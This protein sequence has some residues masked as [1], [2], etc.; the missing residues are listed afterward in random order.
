MIIVCEELYDQV[1]SLMIIRFAENLHQI[2]TIIFS[3]AE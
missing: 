3:L 1:C 2:T